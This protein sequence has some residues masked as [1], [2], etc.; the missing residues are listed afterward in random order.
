KGL[1]REHEATVR[2]ARRLVALDENAAAAMP[3]QDLRRGE[4]QQDEL[5]AVLRELELQRLLQRLSPQGQAPS[6]APVPAQTATR[7]LAPPR[8][9]GDLDSLRALVQELRPAAAAGLGLSVQL[10][11]TDPGAARAAPLCGL[12]LFAEGQPP[13]Y[14]PLGHRYLGAPQQLAAAEVA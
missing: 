5:S 12:S 4:L 10:S 2:L 3:L 11:G 1:L 13:L 9:I 8:I 6:A 7:A 14:V